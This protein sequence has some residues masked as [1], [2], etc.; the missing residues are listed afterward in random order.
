MSRFVPRDAKLIGMN[1]LY[2]GE[3]RNLE[4]LEILQALDTLQSYYRNSDRGV[5]AILATVIFLI[6]SSGCG[7]NGP[8]LS[9]FCMMAE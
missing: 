7:V 9:S 1:D 4:R 5:L 3:N 6:K 2:K 8:S